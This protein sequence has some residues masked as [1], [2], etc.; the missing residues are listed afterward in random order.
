LK[1]IFNAIPRIYQDYIVSADFVQSALRDPQ[2]LALS[3]ELCRIESVETKL[4]LESLQTT[5][6]RMM[7]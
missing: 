5:L 6:H 2:I 7:K 1:D 4:P 3:D